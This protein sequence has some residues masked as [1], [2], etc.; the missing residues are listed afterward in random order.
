MQLHGYSIIEGKPTTDSAGTLEATNPKTGETLATTFQLA[1]ADDVRRAG[2]AAAAAMPAFEQADRAAFLR[3]IADEIEAIGDTL[4]DRYCEE[5][6]LPRGRAEGER[7]RTCGQL[8]NFAAQIEAGDWNRPTTEAAQPNRTPLPKPA[9]HLHYIAVGP[10]AV[11]SP[12]NFPLAYGVA[13][14]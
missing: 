2:D 10:V 11:F 12:V 9:L 8:R 14:G 1:T 3:A 4:L 7:G 6:A 13:G 5:T